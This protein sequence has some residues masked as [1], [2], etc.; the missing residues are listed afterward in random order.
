MMIMPAWKWYIIPS[1]L[2][3]EEEAS[4][5]HGGE[6]SGGHDKKKEGEGEGRTTPLWRGRKSVQNYLCSVVVQVS[7]V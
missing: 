5:E 2:R 4:G 6:H 7:I 1:Q 3:A